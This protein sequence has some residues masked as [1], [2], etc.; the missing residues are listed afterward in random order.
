MTQT[1]QRHFS[2][3]TSPQSSAVE[4]FR[5]MH[6]SGCFALPNP[7]DIGT[8]VYLQHLGF[9]ALATTSSGFAFTQGLPDTVTAINREDMLEH[10]REV[11]EATPLPVN[12][13]FQNGYADE[14]EG[15]AVSVVLCVATGVAGLSI[16]D[17]TGSAAVPL[18]EAGL[19]IER[20][21]AARAAIDASG[22]P[23]ILTARCEAWLVGHSDPLRVSLERLVAYAEAGADCLYAPGVSE[24]DEI[25]QI[26]KAV[27]PK[28][29]N[30]LASRPNPALS[31]S[32]LADLGVRRVSVGSALSRIAW[33]AFI[34]A[35][36]SLKETGTF[37]SFVDAAPFNELDDLFSK[38]LMD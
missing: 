32:R 24:P 28:P 4:K 19:A 11:V 22:I 7:W 18:Y 20:I 31:L 38:R 34:R 33:G 3:G 30:V 5:T 17:A 36:R 8:A 16:E 26:V 2:A 21:K 23:V 37:D 9:E 10:I 29:V 13:D 14:P 6:Q 25:A 27:S 15:V 1:T 35:A 12:A